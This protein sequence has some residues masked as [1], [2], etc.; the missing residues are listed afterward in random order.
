MT[1]IR[2]FRAVHYNQDKIKDLNRVM[3]PPYDVISEKQQ[4]F[5]YSQS[6]WNFIR[7]MLAKE[8]PSDSK[9]NNRYTRSKHEYDKWIQDKILVQDDQPCIYFYR[10]EYKVLGTRHS[11]LGFISLMRIQDDGNSKVYP[12]EKTHS[13]AKEDRFKL[14]SG[15]DAALSSIFVCFSDRERAVEKAFLND[16]SKQRPFIDVTDQDGVRHMVWRVAD[17]GIIRT[18]VQA[19]HDETLFIADGHHRYEVAREIKRQREASAHKKD[20][21]APYN[22]IMTYFTNID[23]KDLQIFPMHRIVKTFPHDLGFL[24]EM[25]RVDR[26]KTPEE[27][28]LLA[29]KAG[30]NEHAF[31]LYMKNGTWL[32]RLKNKLLIDKVVTEGSQAYKRLDASILKYFILDPVGVQSEDIIYTKDL[33][34]VTSMVDS[35]KA[36]A[37]FIM[38]AVRIQQLRDV[39][40]NGEKMPPKTTYFYPKL[41][42]GLTVHKLG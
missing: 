36:K 37:G 1:E 11:R 32:L 27:L 23:S 17:E 9:D 20:P 31:G 16:V 8:K 30:Q 21:D 42:S 10:Q 5:Y 2:P 22:F 34:D 15:L 39:A 38:N 35:G 24:E 41:L 12:H 25:F 18:I 29:A 7:V 28:V 19:L 13:A 6:E 33:T 4:D 14:W 40:L 26:V 3:C